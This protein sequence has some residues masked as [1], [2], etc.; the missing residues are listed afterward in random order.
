MNS[1]KLTGLANGSA[2]TDSAAF[3][4][5]LAG[6]DLAPLTTEGDL[7]YAN[8]TPAPAR[9]ALGAVNTHLASTGTLPAYQLGLE[10]QETTG[11]TGYTLVNGT[12]AIFAWTAPNDGAL[13]RVVILSQM[14][15]TT[16]EVG[17]QIT[18]AITAPNGLTFTP[19][20]QA[21]TQTAGLKNAVNSAFV[22]ANT[23]V[24]LQQVSALTS[25]A[26]VLWAEMWAS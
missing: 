16:A 6:G 11:A 17:G 20:I 3:G 26:A 4:Q 9:L 7:L 13:H 8:A 5:T 1:N 12:G 19:Q 2:S 25:G 15:V 14:D 18:L 23:T 10:L 21:A 22:E 24:T